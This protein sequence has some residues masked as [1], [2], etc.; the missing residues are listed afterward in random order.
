MMISGNADMVVVKRFKIN[1]VTLEE[2]KDKL[3][4]QRTLSKGKELET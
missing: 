4:I 2:Y 1:I 3:R